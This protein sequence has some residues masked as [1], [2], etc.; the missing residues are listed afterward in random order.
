RF[1]RARRSRP[2]DGD[3]PSRWRTGDLQDRGRRAGADRAGGR[4]R[5]GHRY[6][7]HRPRREGARLNISPAPC[8]RTGLID[9]SPLHPAPLWQLAIYKAEGGAPERI[10]LEG[11]F[12]E[13]NEM[14]LTVLAEKASA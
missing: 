10:A 4:L 1:R 7:P 12:A 8:T 2:G 9:N 6:W 14:G 13:V 3:D 11:G 5:R